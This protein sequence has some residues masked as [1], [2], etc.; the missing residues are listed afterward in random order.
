VIASLS[1]AAA[2]ARPRTRG[3][4]RASP[5]TL[6]WRLA[7][8]HRARRGSAATGSTAPRRALW[9]SWPCEIV[10]CRECS[11]FVFF[12]IPP[13]R[14]PKL[15]T[16]A[17][18]ASMGN[19]SACTSLGCG[20]CASATLPQIGTCAFGNATSSI[21]NPDAC[22][23]PTPGRWFFGASTCP[24]SCCH[25]LEVLWFRFHTSIPVPCFPRLSLTCS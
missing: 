6:L 25:S 17:Q 21:S 24:G 20:W 12:T 18:C 23:T 2:G 16:A 7:A 10:F 14:V 5:E 3:R 1:V 22:T 11:F 15:I 8:R 9:V 4:A 13:P 19:C